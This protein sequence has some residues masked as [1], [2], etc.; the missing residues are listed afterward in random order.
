MTQRYCDQC[1]MAFSAGPHELSAHRRNTHGLDDAGNS[2][3]LGARGS[4]AK[5]G[6][7]GTLFDFSFTS[8]LTTRIAGVLYALALLAITA[9]A[10]VAIVNFVDLFVRIGV[11]LLWYFLVVYA[12][13]ALELLIVVFRIAEHVGEIAQ[14]ER[15]NQRNPTPS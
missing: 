14:I 12:R 7:Y 4:K 9:A 8:F 6:F 2:V 11:I 5:Q 3:Q 13:V 10:A 15:S 1:G